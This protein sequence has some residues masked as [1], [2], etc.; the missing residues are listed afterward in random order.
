MNDSFTVRGLAIA[1]NNLA[2]KYG[3][4]IKV[5]SHTVIKS[6]GISIDDLYAAMNAKEPET[7]LSDFIRQLRSLVCAWQ[8]YTLNDM[9][10]YSEEDYGKEEGHRACADELKY[11]LKSFNARALNCAEPPAPG[12]LE[13]RFSAFCAALESRLGITTDLYSSKPRETEILAAFDL[14]QRSNKAGW[15]SCPP[16]QC[17]RETNVGCKTKSPHHHV[18]EKEKDGDVADTPPNE[19]ASCRHEILRFGSGDYYIFCANTKCGAR[20]VCCGHAMDVGTPHLSNQGVGCTLSG[21]ER[22]HVQPIDDAQRTLLIQ[23][24]RAAHERGDI[25]SPFCDDILEAIKPL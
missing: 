22:R 8:T 7:E 16:N 6:L 23:R 1:F 24:V 18:W 15:C 19:R 20:W 5:D 25:A 3:D 4:A 12:T 11:V 2:I 9:W 17:R 13:F 10:H 21:E 14:W